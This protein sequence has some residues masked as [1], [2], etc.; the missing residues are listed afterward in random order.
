MKSGKCITNSV[1]GYTYA[2]M[3]LCC[4]VFWC[5]FTLSVTPCPES[6]VLSVSFGVG[7]A[8]AKPKKVSTKKSTRSAPSQRRQASIVVEADT[9]RIL[10]EA[11]IDAQVY[12]ASLTKMMT[13]YLTFNALADGRIRL[14]DRAVISTKAARQK[15]TK[16]GLPPGASIRIDDA[17]LALITKSANDVSIALAEKL[18]G[19][20][21][22]FVKRMNKASRSLGMSRTR[23]QNPN[24]LPDPNQT[25]SARD[26]ALLS[27]ALIRDHPRYY[28]YFATREFMFRGESIHNH[29]RLLDEYDGLDGIK[30]GYIN[31]SGF[32]L[33]AS[34]KRGGRRIVGVVFG[35]ESWQS[36][37]ATMARLLDTGFERV[38]TTPTTRTAYLFNAE[39]KPVQVAKTMGDE[40]PSYDPAPTYVE[41]APH[42]TQTYTGSAS[43]TLPVPSAK[44]DTGVAINMPENKP[45]APVMQ[46][47]S[48]P[49]EA[50]YAPVRSQPKPGRVV[51][52]R[53]VGAQGAQVGETAQI[54]QLTVPGKRSVALPPP[55]PQP[56]QP[57]QQ[58]SVIDR[59]AQEPSYQP[60]TS[61]LVQIG[62][63]PALDQAQMAIVRAQ[64]RMPPELQR[65]SRVLTLVDSMGQTLYSARLGSYTAEEAQTACQYLPSCVV[66]SE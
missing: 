60:Q 33:A 46:A 54:M 63:Y 51:Q 52:M 39:N 43:G 15:P 28:R 50:G 19:S 14:S 35:G 45:A 41:P 9:G 2:R 31:A 25:T 56:V 7:E 8:A 4:A 38:R 34:A 44:P 30:T 47:R 27:I 6:P 40:Q 58:N 64:G 42:T 62:A 20:E 5:F 29:N 26:M 37:N 36:R 23:F 16:I 12:P 13:L 1:F 10:H 11:N 57:A 3:V 49:T 21:S 24:G 65:G 32:N 59:Y 66:L 22:A 55:T 48:A 17:I 18:A 53:P 61:W